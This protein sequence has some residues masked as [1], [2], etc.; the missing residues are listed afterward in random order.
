MRTCLH[1][2]TPQE[3]ESFPQSYVC[4][5][6]R[7]GFKNTSIRVSFLGVL[8]RWEGPWSP[9]PWGRGWT[10]GP[11]RAQA[12][13]SGLERQLLSPVCHTN[14]LTTCAVMR[15]RLDSTLD[16]KTPFHF[17]G[18]LIYFPRLSFKRKKT[19]FQQAGYFENS[20]S[21]ASVTCQQR[22][23]LTTVHPS[24]QWHTCGCK[25]GRPGCC[26]QPLCLSGD[27]GCKT[28][29]VTYSQKFAKGICQAR[30]LPLAVQDQVT[31]TTRTFSLCRLLQRWEISRH[32][33]YSTGWSLAWQIF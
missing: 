33:P 26:G 18:L 19:L 5:N 24:V 15:G 4:R 9:S 27:V 14:I 28:S 23:A 12:A 3:L 30:V 29:L 6:T 22:S 25:R 32:H 1:N 13:T 16:H 7:T 10:L 8:D 17:Y 31:R 2:Q 11:S 21:K 20:L